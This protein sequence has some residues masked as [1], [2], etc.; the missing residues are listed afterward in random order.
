[1][2][3]CEDFTKTMSIEWMN[4]IKRDAS[5]SKLIACLQ[6]IARRYCFFTMDATINP[7]P[8]QAGLSPY[9]DTVDTAC[10][11][12]YAVIIPWARVLELLGVFKDQRNTTAHI[13]HGLED[14]LQ[15]QDGGVIS[16]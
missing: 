11:H 7:G 8:P 6:R 14:L 10:L 12:M 15:Q 4:L 2:G 3:D 9:E 16:L 5:N 13:Y 1:M